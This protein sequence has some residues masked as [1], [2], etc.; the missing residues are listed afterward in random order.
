MKRIFVFFVLIFMS[1][2]NK[3]SNGINSKVINKDFPLYRF[4]KYKNKFCVEYNGDTLIELYRG[5]RRETYIEKK[6]L[7]N[8]YYEKAIY[9]K[10]CK[11]VTNG[12]WFS[13]AKIGV[14]NYYDEKGSLKS[15]IDFDD[16]FIITINELRKIILR[17]Y[18]IDI[19]N[20]ADNN[21]EIYKEK[22]IFN[23][24]Y[25]IKIRVGTYDKIIKINGNTGKIISAEELDIGEG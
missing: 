6:T 4:D 3:N 10:K 7:K 2:Q 16:G 9:T 15:Q 12:Y 20:Y 24:S 17:K 11:V 22:E 14:H 23:S 19:N 25:I 18:K 21:I 1:C 5:T 13:E 8:H